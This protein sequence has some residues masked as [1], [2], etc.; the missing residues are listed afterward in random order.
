MII[1]DKL[2][3]ARGFLLKAWGSEATN[4]KCL[5]LTIYV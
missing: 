5:G 2:D 3:C 4:R 1:E